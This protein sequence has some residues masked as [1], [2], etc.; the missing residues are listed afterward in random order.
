LELTRENCFLYNNS[1]CTVNKE[2]LSINSGIFWSN[3]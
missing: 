3:H 1:I 2:V